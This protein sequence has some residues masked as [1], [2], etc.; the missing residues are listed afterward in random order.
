[1]RR[2]QV[3]APDTL[4]DTGCRKEEREAGC[5]K[6][7]AKGASREHGTGGLKYIRCVG[8]C[9]KTGGRMTT[10][11]RQDKKMW[12][13]LTNTMCA[14]KLRI[15]THRALQI[16]DGRGTGEH[17]LLARSQG[18]CARSRQPLNTKP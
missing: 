9:L 8:V 14:C 15:V 7:D 6:L 1:M 5:P 18:F 2:M 17:Y 12:E 16:G 11:K 3:A 13:H 10:R 4:D